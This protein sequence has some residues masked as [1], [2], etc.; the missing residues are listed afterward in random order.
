MCPVCRVPITFDTK[1]VSAYEPVQNE[2]TTFIPDARM[3]QWQEQ[4][5]ALLA[6]Q[7]AKGGLIDLE[8]ERTKYLLPSVC[9]NLFNVIKLPI[10]GNLLFPTS[11]K[12]ESRIQVFIHLSVCPLQNINLSHNFPTS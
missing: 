5:K 8:E 10:K 7:R 4:T 11:N 2:D 6:K 1:K 12:V 9:I 3:R